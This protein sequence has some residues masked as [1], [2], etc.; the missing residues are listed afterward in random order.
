MDSGT[1]R[2][3]DTPESGDLILSFLVCV[4]GTIGARMAINEHSD[5]DD[6]HFTQEG[7]VIT[8]APSLL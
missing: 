8:Y 5:S 4:E 3:S 1:Y 7:V 6:E 2:R